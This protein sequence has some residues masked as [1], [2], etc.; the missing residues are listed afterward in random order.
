MGSQVT[1][2]DVGGILL[3]TI[4]SARLGGAAPLRLKSHLQADQQIQKHMPSRTWTSLT[5]LL[6]QRPSLVHP[7]CQPESLTPN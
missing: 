1:P 4:N 7:S 6:D 2:Q 5:P 3:D